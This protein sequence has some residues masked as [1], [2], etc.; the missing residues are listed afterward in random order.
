MTRRALITGITGRNSSTLAE[1]LRSPRAYEVHGLRRR[2]STFSSARI[3]H[4]Y[5]DPR[6]PETKLFLHYVDL[7][8]GARLIRLLHA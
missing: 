1:L 6:D 3:E 5:Q 8:D 4:L 7:S 2:S